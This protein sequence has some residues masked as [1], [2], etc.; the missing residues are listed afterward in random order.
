MDILT[1]KA[2]PTTLPVAANA[3]TGY[4]NIEKVYLVSFRW[5]I[6]PP[7]VLGDLHGV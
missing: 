7:S 3:H 6:K 2:L 1:E 4:I 5:D